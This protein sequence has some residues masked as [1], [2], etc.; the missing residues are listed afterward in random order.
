M[1]MEKNMVQ[2]FITQNY[3]IVEDVITTGGS[4]LYK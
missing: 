4:F 3:L 1:V 2:E